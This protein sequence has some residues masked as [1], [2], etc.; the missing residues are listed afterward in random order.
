MNRQNSSWLNATGPLTISMTNDYLFR[1]LLQ[2]NNFV[3]RGLIAALLHMNESDIHSVFITNPIN[4]GECITDKTFILDINLILNDHTIINLEMQVINEGNWPERSLSYLC[5]S[6]DQLKSGDQYITVKPVIQIG[7]L[8][9]TLFPD[10]PE[11][12]STYKLKNIKNDYVYSDK[13][14]ISVLDLSCIH[15]ATDEDKMHQLDY[16]AKLFKATTWEDLK[17]LANN[18]EYMNQASSTI[19]QLSQEEQIRLQCRAREDFIRTQNDR[20]YLMEQKDAKIAEL[21]SQNAEFSAQIAE[22]SAQIAELSAQI[23]NQ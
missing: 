13:L 17:M 18:N 2:R 23:N 10:Y 14:R 19:Y 11:F 22:L 6:F 7:I 12:Y 20:I 9:F 21:E 15:L 16:W 3:L 4:L 8:N 5:R 1:A